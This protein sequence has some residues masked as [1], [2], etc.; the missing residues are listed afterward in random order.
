MPPYAPRTFPQL[1]CVCSNDDIQQ[2]DHC[3]CGN[4]R[5]W[6]SEKKMKGEGPG[7]WPRRGG[8]EHAH[9][10]HSRCGT[11][12]ALGLPLSPSP[13]CPHS[14]CYTHLP[15]PQP[16][17][18]TQNRSEVASKCTQASCNVICKP[19]A[20]TPIPYRPSRK[21]ASCMQAVLCTAFSHRKMNCLMP[22]IQL[23]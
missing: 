5:G 3:P 13:A 15:T 7:A 14:R 12:Q 23:S 2:L 21:T 9:C 20:T 18:S 8:S 19:P 16:R 4:V 10:G 22:V 6:L 11:I 1:A 17:L